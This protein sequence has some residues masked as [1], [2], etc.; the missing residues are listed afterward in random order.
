MP[1]PDPH[2]AEIGADVLVDRTQPVVPGKAAADPHLDLER[3]QIQLIVEHGQRAGIDFVKAQGLAHRTPAF[4]H[5]GRGLEQQHLGAADAAFLQPALKFLL[6]RGEIMHFGDRIRRHEA[7]IV[8]VQRI[9]CA[10]IA[11]AYPQLHVRICPFVPPGRAEPCGGR[12][13]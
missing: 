9:A 5:E 8:A 4:V 13:A 6:R 11:Q 10:G 1:D 12:F 7:D 3:S 2:P